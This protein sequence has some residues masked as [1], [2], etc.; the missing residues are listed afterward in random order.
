M[1]VKQVLPPD[2]GSTQKPMTK[3][4]GSV[5]KKIEVIWTRIQWLNDWR[6]NVIPSE[7]DLA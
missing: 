2:A 3:I 5:S 1:E 7:I 6:L 4:S